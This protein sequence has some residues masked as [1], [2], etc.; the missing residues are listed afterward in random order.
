MCSSLPLELNKNVSELGAAR[1]YCSCIIILAS[2]RLLDSL[3]SQST[4]ATSWKLL[5]YLH[6]AN[7]AKSHSANSNPQLRSLLEFAVQRAALIGSGIC[8]KWDFLI[9]SLL[10]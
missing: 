6:S 8:P 4:D 10:I 2:F 9:S 5:V 3:Q 7:T 1:H